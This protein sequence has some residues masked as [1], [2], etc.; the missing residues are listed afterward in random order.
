MHWLKKIEPGSKKGLDQDGYS[1]LKTLITKAP[2]RTYDQL[3]QA[4]GDVC[5]LFTDE[6]CYNF[7][8]AAGYKSK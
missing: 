4:V 5:K 6:E 7:S 1:K 2:E 8:V 3:W